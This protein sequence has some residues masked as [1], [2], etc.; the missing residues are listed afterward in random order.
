MFGTRFW[1][2]SN[3][4]ELLLKTL[5]FLGIRYLC[6]LF[7]GYYEGRNRK[8]PASC[9]FKNTATQCVCIRVLAQRELLC[10]LNLNVRSSLQ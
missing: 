10:Q 5:N 3:A 1:E 9:L 7:S 6:K 8:F 4:L 2:K